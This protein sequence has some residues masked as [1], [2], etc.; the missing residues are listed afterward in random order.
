MLVVVM[1]VVMMMLLV[2][3][4]VGPICHVICGAK[5][6]IL[7]SS[8]ACIS[9]YHTTYKPG[10]VQSS[11]LYYK[12]SLNKPPFLVLYI[13]LI[14]DLCPRTLQKI[15][16]VNLVTIWNVLQMNWKWNVCRQQRMKS[17]FQ[18]KE[19]CFQAYELSTL[20]GTQVMLLVASE[21]GHVYTFATRFVI[22]HM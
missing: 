12:S 17:W 15:C 21:T 2:V 1:L 18:L 14:T 7:N 22:F 19:N 4:L 5:R 11:Y 10:Q 3:M 13:I 9:Y 8:L 20:T 16:L 6:R